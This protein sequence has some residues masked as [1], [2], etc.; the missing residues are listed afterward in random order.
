MVSFILAFNDWG[1]ERRR[2]PVRP[3]TEHMYGPRAPIGAR[4]LT[5]MNGLRAPIEVPALLMIKRV[6]EQTLCRK[7]LC[8]LDLWTPATEGHGARCARPQG[9]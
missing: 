9:P 3:L 1:L 5:H 6:L 2:I 8:A 4:A 7:R